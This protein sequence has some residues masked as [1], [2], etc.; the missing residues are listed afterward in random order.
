MHALV[1]NAALDCDL[2]VTGSEKD[3]SVLLERVVSIRTTSSMA[4]N[5]LNPIALKKAQTPWSL[6]RS[7][8]SRVNMQMMKPT[9]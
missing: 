7:E 9:V 5:V 3:L 4:S 8:C 1:V 2:I 6:G